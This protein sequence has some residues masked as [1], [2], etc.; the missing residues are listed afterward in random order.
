[1]KL[2][3]EILSALDKCT[4]QGIRES[5]KRRLNKGNLVRDEDIVSHFCAYFVPYNPKNKTVLVGGHKKSGLW[6]MPGGHIDKGETMLDTLNREIEEELGVSDFFIE[7][8][9]PFLLTITPIQ[10]DTRPC[11]EHFDV[12]HV[13][14]TDGSDFKVD[15]A[16]YNEVRWLSIP[17]ARKIVIDPANLKALEILEGYE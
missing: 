16:E 8:P 9:E 1:M 17:E 13:M 3:E 6:L 14:E 10:H 7:R 4:D 5:Y 15:Y 2:K 11:R 12:W